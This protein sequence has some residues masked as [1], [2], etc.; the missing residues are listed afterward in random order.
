METLS[1]VDPTHAAVML[2]PA[3]EL[4][5]L[6]NRFMR[7]SETLGLNAYSSATCVW[8]RGCCGVLEADAARPLSVLQHG[9]GLHTR[10]ALDKQFVAS[11]RQTGTPA[12][13][14]SNGNNLLINK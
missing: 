13:T 12:H 9:R 4:R 7:M 2:D 14:S 5:I 6:V 10:A 11:L 8:F 1:D 3:V